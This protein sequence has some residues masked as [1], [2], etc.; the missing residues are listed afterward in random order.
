VKDSEAS[1]VAVLGTGPAG[2]RERRADYAVHSCKDLPSTLPDDMHLVA[3]TEREDA[4]DAF[5]SETYPSFEALPSGARV[6]TSSPRRR[7]QF[8]ALRPELRYEDIRGNIDTRLRKLR[9]DPYDAIVLAAAGMRRLGLRV[10]AHRATDKED[11]YFM[12]LGNPAG[13]AAQGHDHLGPP[14]TVAHH[15]DVVQAPQEAGTPRTEVKDVEGARPPRRGAR[16]MED[17]DGGAGHCRRGLSPAWRG[18]TPRGYPRNG[19]RRDFPLRREQA[20]KGTKR[21]EVRR[22]AEPGGHLPGHDASFGYP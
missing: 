14:G 2:L 11:G 20:D 1:T 4:R 7:A 16:R 18:R 15:L 3:I 17:A 5:C 10:L 19:G 21:Q 12:L 22:D 6:G 13:A 9:D 8:H